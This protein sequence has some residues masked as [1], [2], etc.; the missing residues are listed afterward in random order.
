MR[1][2]D[3]MVRLA[4]ACLVLLSQSH[5]L[6]VSP[7]PQ[8]RFTSEDNAS[9]ADIMERVNARRRQRALPAW[10]AQRQERAVDHQLRLLSADDAAPAERRLVVAPARADSI[11]DDA[12]P[13]M[14]GLRMHVEQERN[15]LFFYPDGVPPSASDAPVIRGSVDPRGTRFDATTGAS[16]AEDGGGEPGLSRLQLHQQR[17]HTYS[18]V[19]TPAVTPGASPIMT[20]GRVDATP[21]RLD[22][23]EEE[24]MTMTGVPLFRMAPPARR[25]AVGAALAHA[26]GA[27]LR[28]SGAAGAGGMTPGRPA[29]AASPL[30]SNAARRVLQRAAAAGRTP[31]HGGSD[32][33]L[34]LR[35]S[36]STPRGTPAPTPGPSAAPTPRATPRPHDD[37]VAKRTRVE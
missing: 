16:N 22:A 7:F 28:R 25:E 23:A 37:P 10:S 12:H 34:A 6:W 27:S 26:A 18:V 35:R 36:Y 24:P 14:T 11:E 2:D 1:L 29:V 17:H 5:F 4:A 20:W 32:V 15:A 19:A 3:F 9:F 21:M 30:L 33:D 8:A 31:V 13:A